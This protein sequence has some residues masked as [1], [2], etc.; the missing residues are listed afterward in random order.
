MHQKP[1]DRKRATFVLSTS[2][3]RSKWTIKLSSIPIALNDYHMTQYHKRE[4]NQKT[5]YHHPG[6]HLNRDK[7]VIVKLPCAPARGGFIS[8]LA[9]ARNA[10]KEESFLTG[11]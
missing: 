1:I 10:Q 4:G 6:L 2:I 3:Y 11:S 9:E 5:A 8:A 7:P